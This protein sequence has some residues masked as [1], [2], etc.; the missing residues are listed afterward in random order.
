MRADEPGGGYLEAFEHVKLLIIDRDGVINHDSAAFIKS[1]EEWR[2]IAGSPQAIA[3][4]SKAGFRIAVATNQSG[5]ARGLYDLPT[6][7]AMHAKMHRLVH[8]AGGCIDAVFFCPHH[9]N[10]NCECRKPRPGMIFEILRRFEVEPSEACMIG[11]RLSDLQAG[12]SAGC[13]TTLVL[14]GVGQATRKAGGLPTGTT[15]R[16][17]LTAIAAELAP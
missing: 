10:D 3:R 11:D 17:D 1:P 14:T 15:V 5:V 4:L 9:E 16:A 6:L 12:H 7:H 13:R 2:P 8:E